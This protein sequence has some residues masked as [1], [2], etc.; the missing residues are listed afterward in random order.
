MALITLF[1]IELVLT[2]FPIALSHLCTS[3][4][5]ASHCTITLL[6]C[7]EGQVY[8]G[9]AQFYFII[10]VVFVLVVSDHIDITGVSP[11]LRIDLL[12]GVNVVISSE[13]CIKIKDS[14]LPLPK[15]PSLHDSVEHVPPSH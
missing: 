12:L 15:L 2:L 5:C 10:I 13:L 4:H 3:Y 1:S 11:T 6:Y 9:L 8:P 14:P 7:T